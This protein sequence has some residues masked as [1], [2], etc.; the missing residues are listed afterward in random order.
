M[1]DDL[2]DFFGEEKRIGKTLGTDF[3]S[4]K[5]TLPLF[6]LL[7][8][9]PSAEGTVLAEEITGRRPPQPALRLRQMDELDVF[10]A[11]AE[12]IDAELTAAGTAVH[13]HNAPL[14]LSLADVLQA[15][16]GNLRR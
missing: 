1:Y 15:Q 3:A 9:L 13:G 4:G 2:A 8:R 11:V 5:L 6:V 16:V 10:A 12:T 7:E 14:L